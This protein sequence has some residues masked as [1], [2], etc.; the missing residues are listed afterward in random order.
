MKTAS[1]KLLIHRDEKIISNE[2]K[3]VDSAPAQLQ[4]FIDE[5]KKLEFVLTTENFW[6]AV[7]HPE[8]FAK[9]EFT[10]K[11]ESVPEHGGFKVKKEI[12]IDTLELPNI[13]AFVSTAKKVKDFFNLQVISTAFI[14]IENDKAVV[15]EIEFNSFIESRSIYISAP[16]EIKVWN[17]AKKMTDALNEYSEV[18]KEMCGVK[19]ISPFHV[20]EFIDME[21][22]NG[23][24]R[25]CPN[26]GTFHN[27]TKKFRK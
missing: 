9:K 15:N 18:L 12:L 24:E 20:Q 11:I 2:R 16:E 23:V 6:E 25:F 3:K 17:A 8:S 4:P 5:A 27:L 10:K 7:I 19:S 26:F 22:V 1:E 13:S 14:K 21:N